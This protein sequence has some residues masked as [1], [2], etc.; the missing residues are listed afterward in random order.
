MSNRRG[1]KPKSDEE[2]AARLRE[3]EEEFGP[4]KIR[5][6]KQQQMAGDNQ[7]QNGGGGENTNNVV[8]EE[9]PIVENT[10]GGG[11]DQNQNIN[12]DVKNDVKPGEEL[13]DGAKFQPNTSWKPFKG[14][15][16]KRDYATPK[17]DPKLLETEIP[18]QNINIQ[19]NAVTSENVQQV[20]DKPLGEVKPADA[21]KPKEIKP[22]N[23]DWNSMTPA[24]QQQ[25][26]SLGVDMALGVY[27]KLHLFGRMYIKVD[28]E[29]IIEMHEDDKIDMNAATVENDEDPDKEITVKDFWAD[30]NKQ[31]DDKFVV[32]DSFKAQ[33]RPPM[34]RLFMKYG[35]G[36]GDGMYLAFKFGEDAATKVAMLYGFKK[37]VGKMHEH[38][39]KRHDKFKAAVQAEVERIEAEKARKEEKA[40][41]AARAKAVGLSENAKLADIEA[42]EKEL[43]KDNN[44]SGG[45]DSKKS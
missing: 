38:F 36:A 14:D 25:A 39:M 6:T 23:D 43:K 17:I 30:F 3:R 9:K 20:L 1:P 24:E 32:S 11:G 5:K 44:N 45:D 41:L 40:K 31:V 27:D 21:N 13:S 26:A 4:Q 35:I 34:E 33:V 37:T 28:E 22:V 29:E 42:K 15:R 7:E 16:M 19:Q 18:E 8:N 2:K 10:G 12:S